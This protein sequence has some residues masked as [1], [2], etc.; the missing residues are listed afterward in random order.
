MDWEAAGRRHDPASVEGRLWAGLRRLIAARRATR[1][2]HAQG[3]GRAVLDRQRPRLRPRRE[4]AGHRLLVLA[5]FTP[6][7]AGVASALA[8][9]RGLD[10]E[11]VEH[12]VLEPYQYAWLVSR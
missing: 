4:H 2:V 5:N 8:S 12:L 9:D 3:D 11:R 7:R 6:E 1:A 10:V